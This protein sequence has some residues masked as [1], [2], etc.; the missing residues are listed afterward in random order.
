M[1]QLPTRSRSD[2]ED[3]PYRP[4]SVTWHLEW[5]RRDEDGRELPPEEYLAR[6]VTPYGDACR[7]IRLRRDSMWQID[8][9]NA[10]QADLAT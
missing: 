2:G 6:L 8:Q 10:F 7:R 3:D 1:I 5:D 9:Q 4:A